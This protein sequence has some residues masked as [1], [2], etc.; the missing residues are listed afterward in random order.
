ML[1]HSFVSH[2]TRVDYCNSV[3]FGITV[4]QT[5]RVQRILNAAARLLLP[6]F[7]PVAALIRDHLH[8]LPAAQGIR[9]KILLL[10]DLMAQRS[11]HRAEDRE[12]PGSSPN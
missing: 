12:V 4:V 3:L 5:D 6:K 9:F 8:W 10:V 11:A 7:A 2:T 1:I